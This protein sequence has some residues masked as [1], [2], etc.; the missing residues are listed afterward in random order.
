MPTEQKCLNQVETLEVWW[1]NT[2][3]CSTD[4]I[5]STEWHEHQTLY[6]ASLI[7][8]LCN[9]FG[10]CTNTQQFF[11]LNTAPFH[12]I[13]EQKATTRPQHFPTYHTELNMSTTSIF[14]F[15]FGY[16]YHLTST[17][18]EN[19]IFIN[20]FS[21]GTQHSPW[22]ENKIYTNCFHSAQKI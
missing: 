21:P 14:E 11:L 1:K 15:C 22:N 9:F 12:D 18:P 17:N 8:E 16:T 20:L 13:D 5:I 2:Q 4:V 7:Q 3:L 19:V 10:F 6:Q